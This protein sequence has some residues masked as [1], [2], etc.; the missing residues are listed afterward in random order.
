M[1]YER[2]NEKHILGA[3]RYQAQYAFYFEWTTDK[4]GKKREKWNSPAD[5]EAIESIEYF[6]ASKAEGKWKRIGNNFYLEK[7]GD[8]FSIRLFF[9]DGLKLI[10]ATSDTSRN[11]SNP[12]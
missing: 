11:I 8:I 1:K 10:K 6:L 7:L 12:V 3:Y 4:D 2:I 9:D 5:L